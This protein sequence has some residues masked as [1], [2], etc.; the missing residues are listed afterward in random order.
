VKRVLVDINVVLDV[1][2]DRQPHA[3][4]SA[5]VWAGIERGVAE[6]VLAAH[7]FPTIHYLV[8][9][10]HGP[11]VAERT[12]GSLLKVFGVASVDGAVIQDALRFP[13]QDFEDAVT[14]AGAASA[15]C[16]AIITRDARRFRQSP[17]RILTPE[18]AAPLLEGPGPRRS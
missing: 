1:L 11:A 10:E 16:D 4:A 15:G 14:A 2:L 9:K 17:V 13:G 3:A 6:G 7:A 8:R 12:L 5:A 18:A